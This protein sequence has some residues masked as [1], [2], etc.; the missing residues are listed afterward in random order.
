MQ[1][2]VEYR[3]NKKA[4]MTSALFKQWFHESFVKQVETFSNENNLTGHALLLVD[5]APS[6]AHEYELISEDGKIVTMFLPPNCTALLQPMDQNTIRLIKLHYRKGLLAAILS[7]EE[8]DI[9]KCIKSITIKDATF[10]LSSAWEKVSPDIIAK[11]WRNILLKPS[12]DESSSSEYDENDLIPLSS[13]K[14]KMQCNQNTDARSAGDVNDIVSMLNNIEAVETPFT[15]L[16]VHE[17]IDADSEFLNTSVSDDSDE[18]GNECRQKKIVKHEDAIS[19]F[20]ICLQWAEE[21]DVDLVGLITLRRLRE[22]AVMK[23]QKT[24]HQQKI[25]SFFYGE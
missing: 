21:N 3:S 9:S 24:L 23:S 2:P 6:N 16:E 1:I 22:D 20:N 25:T 10:L 4:W 15:D 14:K 17:W 11:C 18:Y 19:S 5:N 12:D 8:R 13:L 7:S